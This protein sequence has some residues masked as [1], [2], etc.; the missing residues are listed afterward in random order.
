MAQ[1]LIMFRKT[2]SRDCYV[3]A[4]ITMYDGDVVALD[5]DTQ[6]KEIGHYLISEKSSGN[7]VEVHDVAPTVEWEEMPP[8][9]NN[10]RFIE[11]FKRRFRADLGFREQALQL[12]CRVELRS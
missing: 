7:F 2:E 1:V 10:V 8:E 4:N 5:T 6:K 3:C 9:L 12:G 11:E